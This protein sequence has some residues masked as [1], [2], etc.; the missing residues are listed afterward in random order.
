M[1]ITL[2]VLSLDFT[3]EGICMSLFK[4]SE[5]WRDSSW[6]GSLIFESM[7]PSPPLLPVPLSL[8]FHTRTFYFPGA[9]S[10]QREKFSNIIV[11]YRLVP[12]WLLKGRVTQKLLKHLVQCR[13][14]LIEWTINIG[15][16][17]LIAITNLRGVTQL[18]S[19]L[20][21]GL[22]E[23][24][25]HAVFQGP[26]SFPA[27]EFLGVLLHMVCIYSG[28]RE[29]K[30]GTSYRRLGARFKNDISHFYLYSTGEHSV[31]QL[32][33]SLAGLPSRKPNWIWWMLA[34]TTPW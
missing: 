1:Y 9:R 15:Q 6:V 17:G 19:S 21:M 33:C 27:G 2:G 8:L 32:H 4:L 28:G 12:L 13:C 24:I 30:G 10:A 3:N 25:L 7:W 11:L 14:Y 18:R 31:I 16:N 22:Q 20:N 29:R 34:V 23:T 26:G 5:G